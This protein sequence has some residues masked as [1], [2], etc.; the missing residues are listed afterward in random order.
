MALRLLEI[1][2]PND[3]DRWPD[4]EARDALLGFW[5]EPLADD[6]GQVLRALMRAEDLEPALDELRRVVEDHE[7]C[8]VIVL[9][10]ETT[11]PHPDQ[12]KEEED[13]PASEEEDEEDEEDEPITA[14]ISRE[15]LYEDVR[16]SIRS[17]AVYYLL[18]ALAT[19]VAVGG[20]VLDNVVLII[21]AMLIAPLIGPGMAASLGT[22]LAD[23]KLLREG[24]LIGG[25]GFALIGIL[26]I[27]GG[28][29]FEVT[30]EMTQIAA[31]SVVTPGHVALALAAGIAGALSFTRGLPGTLTGVMVAVAVLPPLVAAGMLLGAGAARPAT[32]ALLLFLVNVASINLAGVVTFLVQGIQPM[33][34]YKAEQARKAVRIAVVLWIAVLALLV[35]AILLAP[36]VVAGP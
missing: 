31:Q 36:K 15:E 1:Y 6:E 21:G 8:R 13:A 7:G 28:L 2:V 30:P 12:D 24:L 35:T 34:W 3:Y 32:S 16:E 20:M 18:N 4:E 27:G 25:S 19:T 5:K 29:L 10:V 33:R 11:V 26:S 9:S 17:P 14:R 23:M 22:T